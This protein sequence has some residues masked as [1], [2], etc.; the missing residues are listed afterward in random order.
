MASVSVPFLQLPCID[1]ASIEGNSETV[2]ES[3]KAD[4]REN[5]KLDA[6]VTTS[7]NS[8][9]KRA[10]EGINPGSTIP[11]E[12]SRHTGLA[13]STNDMQTFYLTGL[14]AAVRDQ[15]T[16]SGVFES[17][18]NASLISP[19][20]AKKLCSQHEFHAGLS[21][22]TETRSPVT[23]ARGSGNSTGPSESQRR[24]LF[25]SDH[26]QALSNI[27]SSPLTM[28]MTPSSDKFPRCVSNNES[29]L[30]RSVSCYIMTPVKPPASPRSPNQLRKSG[31]FGVASS[32]RYVPLAPRIKAS[33]PLTP[34]SVPLFHGSPVIP[35]VGQRA[36]KIFGLMGLNACASP[37]LTA[38]N[39]HC[40]VNAAPLPPSPLLTKS[41]SYSV[42]LSPGKGVMQQRKGVITRS[43]SDPRLILTQDSLPP[44]KPT[45]HSVQG[46]RQS[47]PSPGGW[48][49][50]QSS[51]TTCSPHVPS[52]RQLRSPATLPLPPP[53]HL[54][55]SPNSVAQHS[56]QL[57]AYPSTSSPGRCSSPV[58]PGV[59]TGLGWVDRLS[60]IAKQKANAMA[61]VSNCLMPTRVI[62]GFGSQPLKDASP[63][64]SQARVDVASNVQVGQTMV[65]QNGCC[66]TMPAAVTGRPVGSSGM[67]MQGAWASGKASPIESQPLKGG[68]DTLTQPRQLPPSQNLNL[69]PRSTDQQQQPKSFQSPEQ[70]QGQDQQL[71]SSQEDMRLLPPTE[72]M[73]QM[74]QLQY[75]Q[76]PSPT[77][78]HQPVLCQHNA[79]Q[80]RQ[81]QEQQQQTRQ[82][83]QQQ[84]QQEQ[85]QQA[86]QQQQQQQQQ[87]QQRAQQEQQQQQQQ[88]QQQ[89]Q[90]QTIL[91]GSPRSPRPDVLGNAVNIVP[92]LMNAAP[93]LD[94]PSHPARA[95]THMDC[96][97]GMKKSESVC[98]SSA[99]SV[100]HAPVPLPRASTA[101]TASH[102]ASFDHYTS[103]I[104]LQ[105]NGHFQGGTD[106][107]SEQHL[108]PGNFTNLL[109]YSH[110]GLLTSDHLS[111]PHRLTADLDYSIASPVHDMDG[112]TWTDAGLATVQ[113]L[114]LQELEVLEWLPDNDIEAGGFFDNIDHGLVQAGLEGHM[115]LPK[116]VN[117]ANDL[118][119]EESAIE[120]EPQQLANAAV[121]ANDDSLLPSKLPEAGPDITAIEPNAAEVSC[122]AVE[123]AAECPVI[124]EGETTG[125]GNALS[126][127]VHPGSTSEVPVVVKGGVQGIFGGSAKEQDEM[128]SLKCTEDVQL[129]CPMEY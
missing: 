24:A 127:S 69:D 56:P 9:R 111:S 87:E 75:S 65:I 116:D 90:R 40:H 81:Q 34:S 33:P 12:N 17:N 74:Q 44:P 55:Q 59:H 113:E 104:L 93:A 106:P 109:P 23:T 103:S 37:S 96:S 29:P 32:P 35:P 60:D 99:T 128:A 120:L 89:Q 129:W 15:P 27:P 78:A 14:D 28:T 119:Q 68:Y 125:S 54:V 57:R 118:D 3:S 124:V 80:Y 50:Q 38:T 16:A 79:Y 13:I 82:E 108:S 110:A 39:S 107:S 77:D 36:A 70:Q 67:A 98:D 41:Q 92:P 100:Q 21:N 94:L 26:S 73:Q 84:A 71:S 11:S 20:S 18:V 62:T 43:L 72:V 30:Q 121:V 5:G 91:C 42:T 51:S 101:P 97:V 31:S 117:T 25:S 105:Q 45:Q 58:G 88:E 126:G 22:T 2:L 47:L 10:A 95:F 102:T 4:D 53:A 52:H 8:K 63:S 61:A 46:E 48:T 122:P 1:A 112:A 85:Q 66:Q 49:L 76:Q 6:C 19:S 115:S 114:E 64:C 7:P 83:Q 86:Q 123:P